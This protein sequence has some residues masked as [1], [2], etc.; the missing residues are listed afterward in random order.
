MRRSKGWESRDNTNDDQRQIAAA[1]Y[2]VWREFRSTR[3]GACWTSGHGKPE[4]LRRL[5][6]LFSACSALPAL[7]AYCCC[8]CCCCCVEAESVTMSGATASR[9]IHGTKGVASPL[10]PWHGAHGHAHRQ[11]ALHRARALED[12]A[13]RRHVGVVAADGHANVAL[14]GRRVVGRIESDPAQLG[15]QRF[16]PRVR[17]AV[18]RSIRVVSL[19][20]QIAA[21]VAARDAEPPD[22]RDHDVGEVLADAAARGQRIVDRRI[23]ARAL[24]AVL[25]AGVHIASSGGARW[26]ADRR[27]AR[28]RSPAASSSSSAVRCANGLGLSSSQ[29]SPDGVAPSSRTHASTPRSSGSGSA[30][31]ALDQR[32]GGQR[33]P[34]V[35][36]REC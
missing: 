5:F 36:S 30:R 18:R 7:P 12:A 10:E 9:D 19:M 34:R 28:G 14:A 31:P 27:L 6:G 17:R 24:R 13:R 16:D 4:G 32:L 23:D 8:C 1:W 2:S 33:Q 15:Q 20:E 11:L 22:Q 3:V 21:H 25:E 35:P 26:P 29:N